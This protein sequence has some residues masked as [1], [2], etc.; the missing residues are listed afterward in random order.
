MVDAWTRGSEP[1]D[2]VVHTRGT[3]SGWELT[4]FTVA[5]RRAANSLFG[6]VRGAV[7]LQQRHR[8]GHLSGYQVNTWFGTSS[9]PA[10]LPYRRT[11]DAAVDE[12]V[13]FLVSYTPDPSQ[14][15]VPGGPPPEQLVNASPVT[16][17]NEVR[18]FCVPLLGAVPATPFYALT[19]FLLG[20]SFQSEHGLA[21][22][23]SRLHE[24][25]ARKDRQG[26]DVLL[27]SAGAPDSLGQSH[28]AEEVLANWMLSDPQP[29]EA[30]HL[31][32]VFLHF[33]SSGAAY[34]L[35]GERPKALWAP[36]YQGLVAAHHP[37]VPPPAPGS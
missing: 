28:L 10:G 12:L 6:R 11:D 7:A 30:V 14:F 5:Q 31:K 36:I 32:A 16:A 21:D 34:S 23:W 37:L 2:F 13:E 29:T 3:T 17:P 27:I 22:E 24:K 20:L 19:G 35:L 15:V 26:N 18:F 9:E 33:W 4:S 8:I 25:I 1:P